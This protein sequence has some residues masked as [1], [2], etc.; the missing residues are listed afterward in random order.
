MK[1]KVL[2]LTCMDAGGLKS[3]KD[4]YLVFRGKYSEESFLLTSI[5]NCTLA[6]K[7]L[8]E[9][10]LTKEKRFLSFLPIPLTRSTK[11]LLRADVNGIKSILVL[12]VND[13]NLQIVPFTP[14]DELTEEMFNH[15]VQCFTLKRK[16]TYL[17]FLLHPHKDTQVKTSK[18]PVKPDLQPV[19][20]AKKGFL[21]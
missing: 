17:S 2:L 11:F 3:L 10:D 19:K 1:N 14:F 6:M 4:F 15:I 20:I 9:S 8:N 18:H 21:S 13:K 16:D 7:S 12:T 5:G